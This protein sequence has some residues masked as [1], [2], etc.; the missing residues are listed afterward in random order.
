M[1]EQKTY[2]AREFF[3]MLEQYDVVAVDDEGVD[4]KGRTCFGIKGSAYPDYQYQ[5]TSYQHF[6]FDENGALDFVS[7]LDPES[8]EKHERFVADLEANGCQVEH[9][10]KNGSMMIS[11]VAQVNGNQI[12]V[13]FKPIGNLDLAGVQSVLRGEPVA[14]DW[15]ASMALSRTIGDNPFNSNSY[16][17]SYF[18]LG[19]HDFDHQVFLLDDKYKP[20]DVQDNAHWPTDPY[21]IGQ[22]N[23][24]PSVQGETM[25]DGQL[26]RVRFQKQYGNHEL[27]DGEIRSLLR[28]EEVTIPSR[29]GSAT[30]K[31]AEM[32]YRGHPYIGIQK[33]DALAKGRQMPD[34]QSVED[35]MSNKDKQ[36]GE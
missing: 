23:G 21:R 33:V 29:S 16:R 2:T 17:I 8:L 15:G 12:P 18:P 28:G 31:L 7:D 36:P 3:D 14:T 24:K 10:S 27:E 6:Y 34:I 25:V 30:V 11:A 32:E 9:D 20:K 1:A 13:R 5:E 22:R 35:Y 26:R 19:S 4:Y